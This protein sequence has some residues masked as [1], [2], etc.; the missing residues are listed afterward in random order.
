M[1]LGC[2]LERIAED[3]GPAVGRRPQANDLGA[4]FDQPV[5]P[6][7]RLVRQGDLNSRSAAVLY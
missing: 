6:V 5:V 2:D 4:E 3:G 1:L 7:M